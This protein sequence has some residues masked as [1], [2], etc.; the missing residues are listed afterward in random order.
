MAQAYRYQ[1]WQTVAT[2]MTKRSGTERLLGA[3]VNSV[4]SMIEKEYVPNHCGVYFLHSD[5]ELGHQ[6]VNLLCEY[7]RKLG[8]SPVEGMAIDDL[9]D[10]DPKRFRTKGLRNR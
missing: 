6:I 2:E 10:Q 9:Q 7:Y 4:A 1:Y 5:T 8:H 3:E